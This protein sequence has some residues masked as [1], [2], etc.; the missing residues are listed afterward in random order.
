VASGRAAFDRALRIPPERAAELILRA[1]ERR[2]ARLLIGASARL[3]DV[4]ARLAPVGH[5]LAFRPMLVRS[6]AHGDSPSA[7]NTLR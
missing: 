2:K 5:S 3:P 4:A 1:V 6:S 7:R